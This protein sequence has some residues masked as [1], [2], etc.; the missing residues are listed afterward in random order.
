MSSSS[1]VIAA[2]FLSRK[3]RIRPLLL[4]AT[5][6]VCVLG[7]AGASPSHSV[8]TEGAA[9]VDQAV[10]A[11]MQTVSHSVTHDGPMAWIKYF[12]ASPAFFMAVDGQIAFP[13]PAAAQEGTRKFANTIRHIELNW[14]DDLRVDPLNNEFAVVAVSWREIQVDTAGHSITETGY[15]T[16]LTEYQEGQWKFRNAHWS[17]PASSH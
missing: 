13:N 8:T 3:L 15:F 12:D 4:A 2:P 5:V 9:S 1:R 17:S 7:T 16:G 6:A 11:F 14:G 10:R